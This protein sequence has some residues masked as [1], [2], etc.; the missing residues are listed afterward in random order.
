VTKARF[1]QD[2]G[3]P[4]STPIDSAKQQDRERRQKEIAG[5]SLRNASTLLKLLNAEDTEPHANSPGEL[6]YQCLSFKCEDCHHSETILVKTSS[7]GDASD[8]TDDRYEDLK[9]GYSER[10]T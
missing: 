8:Q 1:S 4:F 5:N 7:A 10:W 9:D 3:R 2:S 6:G